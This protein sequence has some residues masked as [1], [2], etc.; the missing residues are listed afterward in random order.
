MEITLTIIGWNFVALLTMMFIG[1][2]LS[3]VFGNVTVVDTLWGLGFVL[4]A[5]IT[6]FMAEGYHLRKVLIVVL[7]TLWGLRLAGHLS[8]RNW[9]AGED[10]RYGS[11]RKASGKRFWIVSLFKI[12]ILQAI[13]LW[14][15]SLALQIGQIASTPDH[16]SGF[17]FL[18]LALW[19]LG[20]FFESVSDFQLARFKADAN[21]KGKV[22]NQGLWAYS[23]H[24][25][26]FGE[27][28]IWWG[29]FLIALATPNSWWTVISPLVITV[30]LL[31][32]TGIPLTEKSISGRR[33]GYK[34]YIK[35][36]NAFIPWFPRKE[37]S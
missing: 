15:I 9:G 18:G 16:L 21:N 29:I 25:N 35:H 28:L 8:C 24:P 1:W 26:Y 4:V 11:W 30:V 19:L 7:T 3:L 12:F 13:F 23:R 2:L 37:N 31:K 17:D 10:P 22:M 14:V 33:P 6:F 5:W 27:S 34:D 36:T 32:M 20:F